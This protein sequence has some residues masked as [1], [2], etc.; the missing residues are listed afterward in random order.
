[1]M[2]ASEIV[3]II[4]RR[5]DSFWDRQT[6]GTLSDDLVYSE[7]DMARAMADEYDGLLVEAGVI[8]LQ[9]TKSH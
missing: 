7:A 9:E 5:R 4:K 8:T 1:M 6:I 2:N 3:E